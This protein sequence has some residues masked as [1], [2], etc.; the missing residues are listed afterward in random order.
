MILFLIYIIGFIATLTYC[1]WEELVKESGE[2]FGWCWGFSLVWFILWPIYLAKYTHD[3]YTFTNP[4]D[5][6]HK[7]LRDRF[8]RKT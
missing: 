5:K 2:E 7:H 8:G 6:F 4:M 1:Y 3:K